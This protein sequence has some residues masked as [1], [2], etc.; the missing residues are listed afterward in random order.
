MLIN[1][2]TTAKVRKFHILLIDF[3]P[4]KQQWIGASALMVLIAYLHLESPP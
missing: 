2:P 1:G 3:V 4:Y